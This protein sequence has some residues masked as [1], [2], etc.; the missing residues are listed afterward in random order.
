MKFFSAWKASFLS[1]HQVRRVFI[2]DGDEFTPVLE[3]FAR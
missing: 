1:P 2:M 3:A